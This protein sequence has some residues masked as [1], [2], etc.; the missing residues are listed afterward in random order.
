MLVPHLSNFGQSSGAFS[1]DTYVRL[2]TV[3]F[4]YALPA[5]FLEEGA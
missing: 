1:N 2:K 3:A 4:S 5:A